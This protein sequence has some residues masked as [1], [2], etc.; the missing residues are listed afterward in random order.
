MKYVFFI[1]YILYIFFKTLY[2]TNNKK[3][4]EIDVIYLLFYII[5]LVFKTEVYL[6]FSLLNMAFIMYYNKKQ[7]RKFTLILYEVMIVYI[8]IVIIFK[9]TILSLIILSIFDRYI[10][11]FFKK[12]NKKINKIKLKKKIE[13]MDLSNLILIKTNNKDELYSFLSLRHDVIFINDE[14]NIYEEFDKRYDKFTKIVVSNNNILPIKNILI[15]NKG[16][17]N[18]DKKIIISDQN[19]EDYYIKNIKYSKEKSIINYIVKNKKHTL[20]TPLISYDENVM[21]LTL[22][23]LG[24]YLNLSD[25]D[26]RKGLNN[27]KPIKIKI[28]KADN[29]IIVKNTM[30]CS[31]NNHY[32]GLKLINNYKGNKII[33][34]GGIKNA[35]EEINQT[36]GSKLANMF[37]YIILLNTKK[38][39]LIYEK[40][41]EHNYDQNKIYIIEKIEE[42]QKIISILPINKTYILLDDDV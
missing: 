21:A 33:V 28:S 18:G 14:K 41:L 19:K 11:L 2:I 39:P 25:F 23:A 1:T 17:I 16:I 12:I 6:I 35:D 9:P 26:I 24:K 37:N 15:V 32:E 10:I 20:T 22:F 30:C 34:T 36:F 3:N 40:L 8:S 7:K 4:T 13:K 29:K 31:C 42:Y 27:L 5:E 38:M